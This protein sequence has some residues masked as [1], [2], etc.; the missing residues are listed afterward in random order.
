MRHSLVSFGL[1]VLLS[2]WGGL[3]CGGEDDSDPADDVVSREAAP[4]PD[5]GDPIGLPNPASVY[6]GQQG[7]TLEIR[8]DAEGNQYGVCMF[9][10]GTECEEWAFHEGKCAPGQCE[11]WETC[12]G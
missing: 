6:C 3:G 11:T 1:A 8:E 2:F 12:D 9:D 5:L 7:G 10:D 4:E